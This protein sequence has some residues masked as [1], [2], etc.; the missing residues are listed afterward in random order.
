MTIY[1]YLDT[2]IL[3]LIHIF[4]PA[5][6]IVLP[7][8]LSSNEDSGVSVHMHRLTRALAASKHKVWMYMKSPDQTLGL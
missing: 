8:A 3:K 1:I 5:H 4:G 7:I 2:D 6:A